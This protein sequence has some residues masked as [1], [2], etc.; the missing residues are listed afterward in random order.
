VFVARMHVGFAKRRRT[1]LPCG[2]PGPGSRIEWQAQSALALP[3]AAARQRFV[4]PPWGHEAFA[5]SRR[6]IS[7][8]LRQVP[9]GA[10]GA[11]RFVV[12]LCGSAK[13]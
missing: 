13:S 8:V 2:P 5:D 10:S 12:Q 3:A 11:L 4:L 9:L 7:A 6:S 1:S